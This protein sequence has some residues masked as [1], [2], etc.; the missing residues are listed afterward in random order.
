LASTPNKNEERNFDNYPALR[1]DLKISR[2]VNKNSAG[3]VV[4]DPLKNQFFKFSEE[5]WEIIGM[6]DGKHTVHQLVEVYHKLYPQKEIDEET[7]QEY[8][9]NLKDLHLLQKNKKDMNILLVE[10]VKEMREFQLLSKEGSLLYRR[11]PVIDPDKLFDR[12]IPYIRWIWTKQF[13]IFSLLIMLSAIA[14]IFSHWTE[15]NEGVYQVFNFSEMSPLNIILLWFVIYGTIALHEFG[16]GLTCKF[17]GGEVHEIGFLLLFFQPCLYCNVNDAWLFDKKWKQI[18]VTIAG[19][20]VEFFI[21][22]LACFVWVLTNPNTLI[23]TLS[24]QVVTIC[25]ISTVLFNF[26][27]LMKLDGYYLLSDFLEVPNLKADSLKYLKHWTKK[28]I[29]KMPTEKYEATKR[30]KRVLFGYGVASTIYMTLL[31]T[32]LVGM[33]KGILVDKFNIFGLFV[34]GFIAYKLFKSHVVDSFK[35]FIS[36]YL[37]N[38]SFFNRK[39]IKIKMGAGIVAAIVILFVPIRYKIKGNCTLNPNHS[40]ILRAQIDGKILDFKAYDGDLIKDGQLIA[41][42]ENISLY[43][44]REIAHYDLKKSHIKVRKTLHETPNKVQQAQKEHITKEVKWKKAQDNYGNLQIKATMPSDM[45]GILSCENQE[46]LV[47]KFIKKGDE[48][49]RVYDL[50]TLR[51][52]VE[53][54]ESDVQYLAA[55]QEVHFKL[56]SDPT[57]TYYGKISSIL[58]SGKADPKNPSKKIYHAVIQ[59]KNSNILRPSMQGVAKIYA[60]KVSIINYLLI[61][62]S[63]ALR[64]DLFF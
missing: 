37:Q 64:L 32:G 59:I 35:F 50:H 36:F 47:H 60:E 38:K 61:K 15:F 1:D 21:G 4:K 45:T 42:L 62:L 52:V 18:M 34:T 30:E 58:P 25:S 53:I 5:E 43:H 39:D 6:F 49:C 31:L 63:K 23:N 44:Q 56:T 26:N 55:N 54:E 24:F 3:Y 13:L 46:E 14:V 7:I 40:R 22:S 12:Y 10:K 9:D 28:Y 33:A 16:H 41:N 20:Y 27:P 29:F 19:G 57:E 17:Y 51:T 2:M 48:I 8:R 11:F